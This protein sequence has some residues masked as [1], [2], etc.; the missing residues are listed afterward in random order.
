MESDKINTL[1]MMNANVEIINRFS[2]LMKTDKSN[3]PILIL[4]HIY[5]IINLLIEQFL[6]ETTQ[7]QTEMFSLKEWEINEV[8]KIAAKIE[9]YPEKKYSIAKSARQSG[10]TVQQIQTGFK[11]MYNMTFARF[12]RENRLE[13]AAD[14]LQK[15]KLNVTQTAYS[16]GLLS[17]SNFSRIFK[18]KYGLSPS[19]YKSKHNSEK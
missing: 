16:V 6:F 13:K 9:K 5:M 15:T 14:L 3:P 17:R 18:E 10:I 4:S 1:K 2:E 19:A 8:K 7:D 11:E 12:V